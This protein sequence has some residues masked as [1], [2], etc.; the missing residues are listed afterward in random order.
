MP[1][2]G[3]KAAACR[4]CGEVMASFEQLGMHLCT[5][6]TPDLEAWGASIAALARVTDPVE[7]ARIA[8]ELGRDVA[9]VF[10]AVR[11]AAIFEATRGAAYEDV[12]EALGIGA[13]AVSKA[14]STHTHH[15]NLLVVAPPRRAV[16]A[17]C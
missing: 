12:A 1:R 17:G 14:V 6:G 5:C 13:S 3:A 8:G 7:R 11:R 4:N 9:T 16:P 10:A 2:A 15:P